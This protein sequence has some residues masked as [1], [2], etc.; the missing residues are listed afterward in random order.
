MIVELP[1]PANNY[2]S[3]YGATVTLFATALYKENPLAVVLVGAGLGLFV[4]LLILKFYLWKQFGILWEWIKESAKFSKKRFKE[5]FNK[6]K[7][8]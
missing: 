4:L 6:K 1:S 5:M 2:V 8:N 3:R 7:E